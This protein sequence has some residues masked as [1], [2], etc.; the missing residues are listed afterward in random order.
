MADLKAPKRNDVIGRLA[1]ILQSGKD[2]ANQYQILPQVP[3]IGGTG[4]GDM[5]MGKA[6]ELINDISYDGLQAAVRGGNVATGGIGTY[7]ARPAVA[8]AALLGLDVAGIGKG[9]GGLSR[10]SASAL[11]D[12]LLEGGTSLSRRDAL[13][14]L[15]ALA[16]STA[17]A[18]AGVGALRKMSDNVVSDVIH[19]APKVA[20]N[21][22]VAATKN[23]K[24]NSLAEYLAAIRKDVTGHMDDSYGY[25]WQMESPD[26]VF[27]INHAMQQQLKNDEQLYNAHKA[28]VAEGREPPLPW[29]IEYNPKTK[30]YESIHAD[31]VLSPQAKQEMKDLK[32]GASLLDSDYGNSYGSNDWTRWITNSSDPS[33]TLQFLRDYKK[34][35]QTGGIDPPF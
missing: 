1:D 25:G 3:L 35:P 9:L 33:E 19:T 24:F 13:K 29:S 22:A 28:A 21:V 8:D 18:G 17:L 7:G 30:N 6:P 15:G 2:T 12:K 16:G 34:G 23:Y 32:E 27:E 4:L 26:H 11:Y 5:F 20:D 10:R 14:K 31:E